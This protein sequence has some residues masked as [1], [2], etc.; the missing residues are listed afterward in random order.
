MHDRVGG[1][2]PGLSHP[3]IVALAALLTLVMETSGGEQRREIEPG[4]QI[5]P[6]CVGLWV[7]IH[8]CHAVVARMLESERA[9]PG[10]RD[11]MLRCSVRNLVY[12]YIHV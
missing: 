2:L 7:H 3:I 6:R 9:V 11:I 1:A 12:I 10:L 4:A 5:R 8:G